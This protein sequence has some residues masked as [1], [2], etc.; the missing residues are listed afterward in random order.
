[1]GNYY[2]IKRSTYI[3][4]HFVRLLP[5][6]HF[7]C[8][9]DLLGGWNLACIALNDNLGYYVL[10]LLVTYLLFTWCSRIK[11]LIVVHFLLRGPM[12]IHKHLRVS[13]KLGIYNTDVQFLGMFATLWKVTHRFVMSICLHGMMHL[14]LVRS[15]WNLMWGLFENLPRKL[16]F[17]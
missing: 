3:T 4:K 10:L 7:C 5:S 12:H 6:C 1:M 13:S 11:W 14:P 2:T 17:N 16:K 15:S 9:P 8:L